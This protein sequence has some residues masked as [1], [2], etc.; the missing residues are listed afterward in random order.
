[1]QAPVTERVC[2][3]AYY[4]TLVQLLIQ[5]IRSIG[6]WRRHINVTITILD[7]I[8]CPI[9]HLKL[10]LTLLVCPYLSRNITFPLLVQQINAIYRFV[11]MV[12]KFDYHNSWLYLSFSLL[13][14]TQHPGHWILTPS[15]PET[16]ILW[17]LGF[18]WTPL[19]TE[20]KSSVLNLTF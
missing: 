19:K 12:H 5:W 15:R 10:N 20:A 18:N 16:E 17:I 8:H 9:F 13:F 1:M 7:I 2:S 6:L 14:K 11:T 4:R 3:L